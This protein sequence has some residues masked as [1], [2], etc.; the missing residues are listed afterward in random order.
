[1]FTQL[2]FEHSLRIRVNT[3]RSQDESD[4]RSNPPLLPTDP[5][6]EDGQDDNKEDNIVGKV[7]N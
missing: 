3:E 1:M 5:V 4:S 6:S 2:I 7:L